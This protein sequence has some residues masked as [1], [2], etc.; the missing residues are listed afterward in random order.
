ME[1]LEDELL[2]VRH[3]AAAVDPGK[4]RRQHVGRL[5]QVQPVAGR[6][7]GR[8]QLGLLPQGAEKLR[9]QDLPETSAL[10]KSMRGFKVA[11]SLGEGLVLNCRDIFFFTKSANN[12]H[13]SWQSPY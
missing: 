1:E 9:I 7:A 13:C 12:Y 2:V 8:Q 3:K 4:H 5:R 11:M 10:S 6:Q